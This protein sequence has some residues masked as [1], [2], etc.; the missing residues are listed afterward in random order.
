MAAEDQAKYKYLIDIAGG[1]GTTWTGTHS[2]LGLP[3][4]LFHHITPTKDYFH[5]HIKPYVHYVPVSPD[6]SDL[7]EK[8]EWAESNPG[9]AR[10]ISNQA[11]NFARYLGSPEGFERLFREDFVKPLQNIIDAYQPISTTHPGKSWMDIL[12]P[13]G[14]IGMIRVLECKGVTYEAANACSWA[15]IVKEWHDTGHY[16]EKD[17]GAE[18][19]T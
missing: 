9:Q 12:E 18:S 13:P 4:L 16:P 5:S 6:L 2:K 15:D 7:K 11:T 10:T 3:G 8:Y 19:T 14:D 1:G 17:S